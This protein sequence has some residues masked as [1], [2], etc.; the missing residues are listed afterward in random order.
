MKRFALTWLVIMALYFPLAAQQ[1]NTIVVEGQS[2]I[3]IKP[4]QA[5]IA[6]QIQHRAMK[7]SEASQGL[8]R[9]TQEITDLIKKSKL[10]QY[11]LTTDN[12]QVN[13]N[14]IYRKN[15]M[16]D[17]GYIASQTINIKIHDLSNDLVKAVD[18]LGNAPDLQF[19][20]NY[21][22]SD[23][24]KQDVQNDLLKLALADAR[25]KANTIK[26]AMDLQDI[27]VSKIEY[28]T[29][30]DFGFPVHRAMAEFSMDSGA[31]AM[32]VLLPDEQK[33]SDRVVVTFQFKNQ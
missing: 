10:G 13:I 3:K 8:N 11:D 9:K 24:L 20:M 26:E 22:L 32:P 16:T 30:Q 29:Q 17:S 14:R 2:E 6:V 15:T 12:Y 7:A 18:A 1:V 31:K 33:I 4:D 23:I 5:N 28:K 27:Q 25:N 21:M 19:S